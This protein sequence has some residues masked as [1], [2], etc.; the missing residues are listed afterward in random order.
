MGEE[1]ER[2]FAGVERIVR[3][4][5]T[6]TVTATPGHLVL[7]AA[8][9]SG[10]EFVRQDGVVQQDIPFDADLDV[11]DF[12]VSRSGAIDFLG[13][14]LSTQEKVRGSVAPGATE[15]VVS[16]DGALAPAQVIVFT[17]IN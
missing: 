2:P 1:E 9:A 15:I 4:K 11:T 16:S 17:R 3:V 12:S 8:T 5:W 13:T 14:R 6:S 10:Y 7:I